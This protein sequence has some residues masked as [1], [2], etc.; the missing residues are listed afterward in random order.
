MRIKQ[1]FCCPCFKTADMSLD[2]LCRAAA[3]IGYAGL[4]L[5]FRG[6]DFEE[7]VETTQRHN[8]AITT[9]CGH[10]SLTDGLNNRANHGRIEAE[11]RE[12]IDIAAKLGIPGLICKA[13]ARTGYDLYLAHEFTP[14]GDRIDALRQAF[15]ICDQQ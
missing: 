8:L 1:S 9:M 6:D 5:W 15:A 2:K 7:L 14:G 3:E 13:I 4:E 12:S 11:L 10:T